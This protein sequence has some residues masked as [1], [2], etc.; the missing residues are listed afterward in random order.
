[1]DG[2]YS[3]VITADANGKSVTARSLSIAHVDGV[4]KSGNQTLLDLGA[5]GLRPQ[6]DVLAVY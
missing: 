3:F 2:R 5:Y 1:V 4:R 6:T